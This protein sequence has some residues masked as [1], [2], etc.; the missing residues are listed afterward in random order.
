MLFNG[1]I[2]LWRIK[3]HIILKE[4]TAMKN[5]IL[6]FNPDLV[7]TLGQDNVENFF[8]QIRSLLDDFDEYE[9]LFRREPSECME[10]PIVRE[11]PDCEVL[12]LITMTVHD[13]REIIGGVND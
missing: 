8:A 5:E 7:S 12:N 1:I 6:W 3:L 10:R 2:L 13:W 11:L 4:E 9:D